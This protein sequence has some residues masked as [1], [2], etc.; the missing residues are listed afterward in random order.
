[1]NMKSGVLNS[2]AVF[3]NV[4]K[5]GILNVDVAMLLVPDYILYTCVS[6]RRRLEADMQT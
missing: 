3:L 6:C 5:S 4:I 2:Y 1:M